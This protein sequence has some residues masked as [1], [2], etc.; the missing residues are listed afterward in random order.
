MRTCWNST[1]RMI[2]R[3]LELREPLNTMTLLNVDLSWAGRL[4]LPMFASYANV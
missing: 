4:V 3:A 2:E 1:H